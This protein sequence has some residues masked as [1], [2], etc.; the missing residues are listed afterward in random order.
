LLAGACLPNN[1]GA[2]IPAIP[3]ASIRSTLLI[4]LSNSMIYIV[5]VEIAGGVCSGDAIVRIDTVG[6]VS[7][8]LRSIVRR[9]SRASV[10]PTTKSIEG[11]I[12]TGMVESVAPAVGAALGEFGA[13]RAEVAALRL[14]MDFDRLESAIGNGGPQL[15]SIVQVGDCVASIGDVGRSVDSRGKAEGRS[16]CEQRMLEV[17]FG[18][19]GA[20]FQVSEYSK[21]LK[22]LIGNDCELDD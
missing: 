12:N 21:F 16:Q 14:S 2:T 5:N 17:H 20:S 4:H 13:A 9:K 8:R 19:L 18:G 6:N 22:L 11:G 15:R 1:L 3:T 7:M 10:S